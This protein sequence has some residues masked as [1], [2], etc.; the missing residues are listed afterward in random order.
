MKKTLTVNLSGVV[1]NIDEDAYDMLSDYLGKLERHFTKTDEKEV[2]QDIEG[3]IAELFGE[4][5]PAGQNVVSIG[6]VEKVISVMGKPEE[7]DDTEDSSRTSGN[8]FVDDMTE[9]MKNAASEA[10]K[11]LQ[12]KL[13]RRTDQVV[14][15]GV[16]SG[17]ATWAGVDVIVVRIAAL[18]LTLLLGQVWVPVVYIILWALVPEA[19]TA[20]QKLEMEGEAVNV[21]SIRE[22]N[23]KEASADE[24][25]SSNSG[26][27]GGA[28]KIALVLVG[29]A[30]ALGLLGTLLGIGMGLFG[31]LIG[32]VASLFAGACSLTWTAPLG[33]VAGAHPFA[34]VCALM[35]V[36]CP[37]LIIVSFLWKLLSSQK[38]RIG[39]MVLALIL[40]WVASVVYLISQGGLPFVYMGSWIS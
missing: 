25:R 23:E 34:V 16:C 17:L 38:R 32:M 6:M 18:V 22:K 27:V 11:K 1:F 12:K 36:L 30:V 21:E 13:Y 39:G 33:I 5:M 35:L 19:K 31:S 37:I 14:V 2:F 10:Q 20:S 4:M 8:Q 29:L 9:T 28:L 7:M 15:A 26:C 40:I 24:Q 3:R